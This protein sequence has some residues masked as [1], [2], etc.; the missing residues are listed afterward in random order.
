MIKKL[1]FLFFI[2][3]ILFI[4]IG[5]YKFLKASNSQENSLSEAY[6]LLENYSKDH[7]N[8]DE[9]IQFQPNIG[10]TV[11]ILSI[12]K[13]RAELP[14]VEGTS[15]DELEKG[16]GHYKGTAYPTQKDQIVLSGHRD[17]V[18]RKM[19][20]LKIGDKMTVKLPYGSFIYEIE[21]TRIVDADDQSIIKS[22]A[23]VEELV[24]TTC[25]PFTYIGD[26]PD[27]YIIYAKPVINENNV[28]LS[29]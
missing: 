19:G 18:F 5:G 3:G 15:E 22:T 14:I 12:P 27:R 1:S 23:P 26:A 20:E 17:T 4:G 29:H 10:E 25:Y 24:V 28:V 13:I 16:V 11:G 2:T 8:L 9:T 6:T 7:A 21:A